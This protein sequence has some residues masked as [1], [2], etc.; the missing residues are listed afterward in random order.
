MS[1]AWE[2]MLNRLLNDRYPALLARTRVLGVAEHEAEDL[3]Q[4]ALI[5]TFS[6]ARRF[7]S[8]SK[9]EAYVK[10]AIVTAFLDSTRKRRLESERWVASTQS[11][12]DRGVEG[13]PSP[14]I[15]NHIDLERAL[16]GL[17]PRERACV[18]LKYL[19]DLTVP[20]VA[21]RLGLSEGAVKRYVHDG[22]NMLNTALGT[23]ASTDDVDLLVIDAQKGGRS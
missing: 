4:M 12:V 1:D 5:A 9:A 22:L 11:Q 16:G 19:D 23:D 15:G 2:P 18:T 3:V 8:V 21:N 20:A 13:D 7:D 10:Q 14:R 6:R 17:S